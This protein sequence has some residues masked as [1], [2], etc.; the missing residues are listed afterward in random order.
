AC[1]QP[2]MGGGGGASGRKLEIGDRRRRKRDT[3]VLRLR[4]QRRE[5]RAILHHVG[6]RLA[7][8][9][10]AIEAEKDR[11][12]GVSETAVGHHH[13]KNGL[14]L[15]VLPNADGLEQAARPRGDGGCP[16][17][18]PPPSPPPL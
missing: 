13:I 3:F 11:P 7:R 12:H 16:P 6:E 2:H 18:F 4:R 17:I 14:R 5:Q 10:I 8:F 1:G 9:H 15:D